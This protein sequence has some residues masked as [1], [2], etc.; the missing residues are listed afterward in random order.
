MCIRDSNTTLEIEELSMRD[1]TKK[2]AK[3]IEMGIMMD[4]EISDA[5]NK[6]KVNN[7]DPDRISFV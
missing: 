5:L 2:L 7:D 3:E 4:E 1:L 6:A